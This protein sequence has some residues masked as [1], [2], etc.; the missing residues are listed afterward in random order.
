MS[1]LGNSGPRHSRCG[2]RAMGRTRNLLSGSLVI[3]AIAFVGGCAAGN[4]AAPPRSRSGGGGNT[5]TT[6]LSTSAVCTENDLGVSSFTTG[7]G[8]SM[9]GVIVLT[10][11]GSGPCYLQGYL[12]IALPATQG[13]L[14]PVDVVHGGTAGRQGLGAGRTAAHP[15]VV[16]LSRGTSGVAWVAVRWT[17]WCGPSPDNADAKLILPNKGEVPVPAH[18]V[19]QVTECKDPST[20]FV[21]EEGPVQ[22]GAA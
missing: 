7:S 16:Q 11:L 2:R 13:R 22:P 3:V 15:P 8:A 12:G 18:D 20:T 21:I 19:W 9:T 1:Q 14:I 4:N 5:A 17:N 10:D 6:A